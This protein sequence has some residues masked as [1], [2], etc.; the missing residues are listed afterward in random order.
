M[1]SI[2]KKS[3]FYRRKHQLQTS[4]RYWGFGLVL[5]AM[6]GCFRQELLTVEIEIPQMRSEQC[7]QRVLRALGTLEADAI[8]EAELKVA[9]GLAVIKYDSTRLHLKNIEHAISIAGFDAN[10]VLARPDARDALP[11][12]CR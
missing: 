5:L 12:E 3:G 7:A 1:Q 10:D 8:L 4:L 2:Q 6:T 9:E 11:E